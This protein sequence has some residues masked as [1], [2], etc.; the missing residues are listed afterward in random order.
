MTAD[1]ADAL[2]TAVCHAL[3][4]RV[5]RTATLRAGSRG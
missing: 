2:A 5:L 4:G 1:A 3:R